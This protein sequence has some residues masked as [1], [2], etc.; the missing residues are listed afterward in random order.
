[1]PPLISFSGLASGI[2]TEALLEAILDADRQTRIVPLEKRRDEKN[3][4]ISLLGE[5]KDLFDELLDLADD[6]R[7]INGGPL[8]KEASSSN[9]D[10]LTASATNSAY[11]TSSTV[12]VTAIAKNGTLSYE[13][14]STLTSTTSAINSGASAG[15]IEIRIGEVGASD[16]EVITIS[17][18]NTTTLD[19]FV[20]SFNNASSLAV[21]TAVNVGTSTAPN[22]VPVITSLNEGTLKGN[23]D[24]VSAGTLWNTT[25][26]VDA[27]NAAFT[28]SGINSTFFRSTNS[29]SDAIPGITLKIDSTGTSTVT[30]NDDIES[31]TTTVSDIIDKF[32]EAIAF[33]KENNVVA[34]SEDDPNGLNVFG[35]LA[36]SR[37]DDNAIT[38]IRNAL[39]GISYSGGSEYKILSAIGLQT[40]QDGTIKFDTE[41]FQ[42]AL[43][44]EPES[45]RNLIES[46]A[47]KLGAL[48]SQGGVIDAFTQFN[49]IFDQSTQAGELQV[50]NIN[51]NI[52][53][54]ESNLAQKES[55]LRAQFARLE[56]EISRLQSQQNQVL[57]ILGS[58][59]G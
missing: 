53:R 52:E 29:V 11:N 24:I 4:E 45:V 14:A 6:V 44:D 20:T 19:D 13:A 40:Q 59:G 37:V 28:I 22:Y 2:D 21:A 49:G 41:D 36:K 42:T 38:A 58:L 23:I 16:T 50:E 57:S 33:V 54:A 56:S 25:T 10:V 18:D 30:V 26:L 27:E 32:N 15:T 46:L 48:E 34:P 8:S 5:L 12:T 1:M 9:E 47:E 17:Y 7:T 39:S 51:D 43:A 3:E 31:T 35:P 55:S